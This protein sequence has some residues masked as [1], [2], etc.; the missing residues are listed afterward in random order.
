MKGYYGIKV[1][2]ADMPR[3]VW[4]APDGTTRL[5]IR[6]SSFETRELAQDVLDK[7]NADPR[8]AHIIGKVEKFS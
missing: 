1:R 4:L 7:I 5:R 2:T 3:S 8:N 6:A